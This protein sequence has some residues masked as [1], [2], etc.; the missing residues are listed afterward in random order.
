M[1][2]GGRAGCGDGGEAGC[3]RPTEP[4]SGRRCRTLTV[5]QQHARRRRQLQPDAA[6]LLLAP[7]D[8]PA[9]RVPDERVSDLRQPETVHN[10]VHVPLHSG[11]VPAA[12]GQA[13]AGGEGHVLPDRELGQQDVVIKPLGRA[14]RGVPGIA[15]ATELGGGRTVLLLDVSVLVEEALGRDAGPADPTAPEAAHA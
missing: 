13:H 1:A 15:G 7:A 6:P 2:A 5:K 9:A 8:A 11:F 4:P 14:L 12:A 3:K 10:G